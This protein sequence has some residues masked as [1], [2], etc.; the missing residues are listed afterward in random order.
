MSRSIPRSHRL[1][2]TARRRREKILGAQHR[3]PQRKGIFSGVALFL[4]T[5]QVFIQHGEHVIEAAVHFH[6]PLMHEL[7]RRDDQYARRLTGHEQA[8]KDQ[9]RFDGFTKSHFI[10]Q[11]Y[12]RMIS[13]SDFIGDGNLMRKKIHARTGESA[14]T[15]TQHLAPEFLRAQAQRERLGF[16]HLSCEQSFVGIGKTHAVEHFLLG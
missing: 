13:R 4:G 8:M 15:R 10:R 1:F 9:T 5:A 2:H 3:L 7:R 12:A 6:Q 14:H 16:R 11:Q